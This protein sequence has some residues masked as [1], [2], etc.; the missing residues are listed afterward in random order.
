MLPRRLLCLASSAIVFA[1]TAHLA[2]PAE[3]SATSCGD[4]AWVNLLAA[5]G[6][7]CGASPEQLQPTVIAR[8]ENGV[9]VPELI[10]CQ[11]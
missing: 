2:R 3:A 7:L 5:A 11:N 6:S 9:L 1:G 4:Q 8:C 10:I